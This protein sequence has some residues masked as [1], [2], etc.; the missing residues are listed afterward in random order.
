MMTMITIIMTMGKRNA[1]TRLAPKVT[2]YAM[3]LV[4]LIVIEMKV[5]VIL[6]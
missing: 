6:T 3:C 4:V 1:E 2:K 5:F